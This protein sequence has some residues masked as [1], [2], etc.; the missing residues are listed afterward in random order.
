MQSMVRVVAAYL[1]SGR[2]ECG[3]ALVIRDPG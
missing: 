2:N 3:E 1:E